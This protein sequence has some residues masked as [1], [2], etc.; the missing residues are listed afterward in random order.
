MAGARKKKKDEDFDQEKFEVAFRQA[1]VAAPKPPGED[2]KPKRRTSNPM[3]VRER[4]LLL[5]KRVRRRL[6]ERFVE[7]EVGQ[8]KYR[9]GGIYAVA[10]QYKVRGELLDWD[11]ALRSID[12]KPDDKIRLKMII[13]LAKR[14]KVKT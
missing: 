3:E 7:G 9:A 8:T 14:L 1:F 2:I 12:A 10:G 13:E 11:H 4:Y 6:A 5:K